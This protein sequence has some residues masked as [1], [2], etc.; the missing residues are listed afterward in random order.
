M[1][2]KTERGDGKIG[3]EVDRKRETQIAPQ[4][5]NTDGRPVTAGS[6][7]RLAATSLAASTSDYQNLT[8]CT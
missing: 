2:R 1:G 5:S 7:Q 3:V 6:H 4:I 8:F